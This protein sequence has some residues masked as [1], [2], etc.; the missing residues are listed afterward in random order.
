MKLVFLTDNFQ[1]N[2][3]IMDQARPSIGIDSVSRLSSDRDIYSAA[4]NHSQ[5]NVF[6][7]SIF[8]QKKK[9]IFVNQKNVH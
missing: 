1:I 8:I 5:S 3:P 6:V 7:L 4:L 2:I 9:P